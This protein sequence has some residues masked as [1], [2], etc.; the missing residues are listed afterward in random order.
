[1]IHPNGEHSIVLGSHCFVRPSRRVKSGS[2]AGASF[3]SSPLSERFLYSLLQGS[4]PQCEP[5]HVASGDVATF[6][7]IGVYAFAISLHS[8]SGGLRFHWAFEVDCSPPPPVTPSWV[9]TASFFKFPFYCKTVR[10]PK[11]RI[12]GS[13][14]SA[15]L[16]Q[17]LHHPSAQAGGQCCSGR[18]SFR[19]FCDLF[20]W[21]VL[22]QRLAAILEAFFISLRGLFLLALWKLWI[23]PVNQTSAVARGF[24]RRFLAG[25]PLQLVLSFTCFSVSATA[26]RAR[27]AAHD[28]RCPPLRQPKP[29]RCFRMTGLLRWLLGFWFWTLPLPLWAAPSGLPEAVEAVNN[30]VSLLP[31]ALPDVAHIAVP[32]PEESE[33]P[34]Q[35]LDFFKAP[36]RTSQRPPNT[37]YSHGR[38]GLHAHRCLCAFSGFCAQSTRMSLC[39]FIWAYQIAL[40]RKQWLKFPARCL[41]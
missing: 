19:Q 2:Y 20:C 9:H 31:E 18:R 39:R 7:L 25:V 40:F 24:D 35:Q 16:V 6:P 21:E 12:G 15:V 17:N 36:R 26:Q 1:M 37:R 11:R 34:D 4:I 29:T 33:G 23:K 8:F 13:G 14:P 27:Q 22:L 32:G 5:P 10:A 28:D 41:H 30:L 3:G 38:D